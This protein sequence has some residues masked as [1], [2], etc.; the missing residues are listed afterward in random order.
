ME[1]KM[2]YVESSLF[3]L[4]AAAESDPCEAAQRTAVA[5]RGAVFS[6]YP[7]HRFEN[8]VKLHRWKWYKTYIIELTRLLR[9]I[10]RNLDK[11]PLDIPVTK[12][13]A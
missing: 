12:Q 6:L 2:A 4:F 5:I 7:K 3:L 10:A 11:D 8:G 9:D 1:K 13:E